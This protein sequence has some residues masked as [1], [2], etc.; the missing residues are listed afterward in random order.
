MLGRKF[1]NIHVIIKICIFHIKIIMLK[2]YG[3][4]VHVNYFKTNTTVLLINFKT[5]N[6]YDRNH[7]TVLQ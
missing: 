5:M 7:E 4:R 3:F 6:E 2:N 1:M